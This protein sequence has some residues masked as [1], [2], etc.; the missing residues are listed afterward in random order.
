MAGTWDDYASNLNTQQEQ[1]TSSFKTERGH[2]GLHLQGTRKDFLKDEL[3]SNKGK[4]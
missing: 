4:C 3:N 2:R 1:N